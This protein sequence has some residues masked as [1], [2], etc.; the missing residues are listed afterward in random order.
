MPDNED[1]KQ[2][3]SQKTRRSDAKKVNLRLTHPGMY[4]GILL[5]SFFCIATSLNYFFSRPTFNPYD[6]EKELI[7]LIYLSIGSTLLVLL[8]VF[9]NLKWLRIIIAVASGFL[10]FWAISNTQQSFAGKASF[11]LPIL[12]L[13]IAFDLVKDLLEAPVNPMTRKDNNGDV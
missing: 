11:V 2:P 4:R 13:Y 3:V 8:N 12:L 7:G 1:K 6:I 5:F 10:I 9:R